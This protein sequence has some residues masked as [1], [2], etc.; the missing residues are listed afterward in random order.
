MN[1]AQKTTI[2]N[3]LQGKG[4]MFSR[5]STAKNL[6]FYRQTNEGEADEISINT[7]GLDEVAFLIVHGKAN[8][9]LFK[10]TV[11]TFD[12]FED[13]IQSIT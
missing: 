13:V 4:F 10:H 9:E 7:E 2:I 12:E 11:K 8:G 5:H 3:L 1:M 6:E